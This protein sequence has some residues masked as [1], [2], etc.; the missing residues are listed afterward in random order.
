MKLFTSLLGGNL[1]IA[2]A[3]APPH[4]PAQYSCARS[5]T[6]AGTQYGEIV[7]VDATN[8]RKVQVSTGSRVVSF[9][10]NKTSYSIT[11]NWVRIVRHAP[12]SPSCM[13]QN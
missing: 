6:Q 1:A 12:P 10:H 3:Q 11:D 5:Y 4:F 8:Q 9:F 2:A 7:Y 13:R